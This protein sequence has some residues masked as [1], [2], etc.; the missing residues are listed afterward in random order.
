VTLTV[1]L[2]RRADQRRRWYELGRVLFADEPRW[3]PPLVAYEKWLFSPRHP[4]L[5]AGAHVERYLARRAGRVVGRIA[6]HHRPGDDEAWFGGFECADDPAAVRALVD[7]AHGDHAVLRGPAL[8]TPA[9]GDA[10]ILVEGFA[11]PGGTGRPWHPPWY[12]EHLAAAGLHPGEPFPRW[13]RETGGTATMDRGGP[14]PPHA[15][16]L[17]DRA[18]VLSGPAGD[19][20]AVPDVSRLARRPS[21]AAVV[22]C[23]GDAT[24]LVPALLAA[25]AVYEAVW[26]PVGAGPP[27]TVHQLFARSAG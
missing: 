6:V 11:L 5:R 16:R 24:I 3:A 7:V 2:V 21:E 12:A 17:A 8:Y 25:A 9:D 27:D 14:L 20:A 23:E 4:W 19:I 1:E 26:A 18:L 22:R 10:G 13:R 15:G